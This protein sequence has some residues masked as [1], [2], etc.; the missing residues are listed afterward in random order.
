MRARKERGRFFCETEM[1]GKFG[2]FPV[3]QGEGGVRNLRISS[4][5]ERDSA[6]IEEFCPVLPLR[7]GV[8]GE[9]IVRLSAPRKQ[10]R[11]PFAGIRCAGKTA[12]DFEK[13][14]RKRGE[15]DRTTAGADP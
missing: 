12:L 8:I 10:A 13:F 15:T 7:G 5:F 1:L 3:R 14:P 11:I 4:P 2:L 9:N 6:R